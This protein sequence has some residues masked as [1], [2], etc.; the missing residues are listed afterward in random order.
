MQ[1]TGSQHRFVCLFFWGL[2]SMLHNHL[3]KSWAWVQSSVNSW[4]PSYFETKTDGKADLLKNYINGLYSSGYMFTYLPLELN[5]LCLSQNCW[6][7][8]SFFHLTLSLCPLWSHSTFSICLYSCH[9][10]ISSFK[11]VFCGLFLS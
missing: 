6:L 7:K 4:T 5:Y 2:S 10:I 3:P 8:S 9:L 1:W 11:N